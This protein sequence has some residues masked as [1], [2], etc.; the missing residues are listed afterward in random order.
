MKIDRFNIKL[1]Q[2]LGKNMKK[3]IAKFLFPFRNRFILFNV[4]NRARTNQVNLNYWSESK[5]LGDLLSPVVV[6]YMLSLRNISS[7]KKVKKR[8]HF[9]AIGSILTAGQQD[10]VVWGSGI[11]NASLTYRL[12]KR[13]LDI[14][15]VRGPFTRAVLMDYGYHVPEVYGDPAILFPEIYSPKTV[16]KK[17]KYG[18]IFHKDYNLPSLPM[19][20]DYA[21]INICTDNY[22]SFINKIVSAEIIISSSLHGIILAE[23]YGIRAIL[24]KPQIDI[25]KY[26]DYYFSTGRV[27]IP[28]AENI[29]D[30]FNILPPELP[31]F[32]KLRQ[33]LKAAF[34]Y[35]IY[36]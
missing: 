34:P 24:L 32:F 31:D 27:N 5:N 20:N 16:S 21:I 9:Y 3:V 13:K 10:A 15:A 19:D 17:Y 26:Y 25:L 28:V 22:K 18:I 35:D 7:D 4:S 36:N 12:E 8:R 2:L 11:L 1:K 29:E 30:A 6:D 33:K 14:R 23:S